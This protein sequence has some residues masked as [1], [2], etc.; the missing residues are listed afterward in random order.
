MYEQI[1]EKLKLYLNE[2]EIK[3]FE[4][5]YKISTREYAKK[6]FL[7]KINMLE[8]INNVIYSLAKYQVAIQSLLACLLLKTDNINYSYITRE[9]GN[10]V[11]IMLEALVR[12]DNVKEKTNY[13]IDNENYRKI[14]VALAK[15]Y[16]VLIIRLVMQQELMKLLN[17]FDNDFQMKIARE[18]L[19]VYSPIAHRLGMAKLKTFLENT[20]IYYLEREKYLYI[21]NMLKQRSEERQIKIDSMIEKIKNL[22]GEH[23]I[24]YYSIKGR[25]KEIYSIY[26]KMNKKNMEM[27]KMYD[28]LALRII[29]EDIVNCYEILGYIHAVYKP[30]NG[31]FKDYI[32][33]P[34]SN[35]YQSLHTSIIADDGNIY[36]IQIR[37]KE[38]DEWAESGVAAHWKYKENNKNN[39]AEIEEKLH[40]FR[41]FIDA[42]SDEKNNEEYV[43]NLKKEI[44]ESS[45]YV[46]SPKGKVV[47][48]PV[49]S[50]PID[51]AY[52]IHSNVGH[53]CVGALV[54]GVM[55]PLNSELKTGDIIEIKTSKLHNFPSEGWLQIVKSSTAKNYIRKA[56]QKKNATENKE[57]LISKGQ[58]LL[59]EEARNKNVSEKDINEVFE[60][61]T[62]LQQFG[63]NRVEDLYLVISNR[64]VNPINVIEKVKAKKVAN[65]TPTFEFKKKNI[66]TGNN[67]GIIVKGIDSIKVELSQCCCPIPGDEIIGYISR[68]K[69]VKVHRTSCPTLKNLPK[70]FIEVEWDESVVNNVM[71]QV[72]LIIRAADR[73]NLLIEIMNTLSTLKITPL[74]LNA[75]THKENLN[76]SVQL[77]IMVKDGEHYH[78]VENAI[79]NIT[80][81][82]EVE[83]TTR[84]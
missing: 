5:C 2:D 42:N 84:N 10:D 41:E 55:V 11:S 62:F 72:D 58:S 46:M 44:F 43:D 31:R 14:F 18:T 33:V 29:T 60:D 45:I 22:L 47:E 63:V 49:G 4:S 39:Q 8:Y 67:E 21:Q 76:A 28:L 13:E 40:F 27:D 52:R 53:S 65:S 61:I 66:K 82:F 1:I 79:K 24:P 64:A 25:P 30:I 74:E 7:E 35:M 77:S 59:L 26:N 9:Y 73:S 81:V 54:N 17:N 16:H 34:K 3:T 19:D 6:M 15:D 57:E 56:L 75:V 69:G 50:C 37:T 20:S 83:R 12:I 38:M 78:S 23:N 51:F 71:H 48:L 36:E 32:A 68:G 80:G 70:R